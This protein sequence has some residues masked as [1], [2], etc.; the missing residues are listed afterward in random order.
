M[1]HYFTTDINEIFDALRDT[2]KPHGFST[3]TDPERH[4]LW[5]AWCNIK[6][7]CTDENHPKFPIYGSRGIEVRFSSFEE[8]ARHVGFRPTS[9]H[10]IDRIDVDGHYEHG[11]LRWAT[12]SEQARNRRC[13][14][15][16]E[17]GRLPN[18]SALHA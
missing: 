14:K 8:F 11:N 16:P 2:R 12:A 15:R 9:G 4:S 13:V 10:S 5:V 17:F 18:Y 7:R 3:S 6:Q 1:T